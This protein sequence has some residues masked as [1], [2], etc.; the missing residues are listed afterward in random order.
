MKRLRLIILSIKL[1]AVLA[2][3][4][5]AQAPI[6][7]LTFEEAVKIALENSVKLGAEKNNLKLSQ[8]T[9]LGSIVGI[10][11]N[12]SINSQGNRTSGNSF[13]PN[14]GIVTNGI[15]DNITANISA[16][17][18][19][20]SGFSQINRIKQFSKQLEAQ[21]YLI[22]RT[23]Q[24][25]INDVASN[26]LQVMLDYQSYIIAK[27][28]HEALTKQLE[29][30]RELVNLGARSP[31]DEYNQEAQTKGAELRE[32][33]ALIAF[34]NDQA[35][36]S[37]ILLL[38]PLEQFEVEAPNWDINNLL[39]DSLNVEYLVDQSKEYRS[40]YQRALRLAKATYFAMNAIKGQ[41]FP[42]LY[43]FGA[44]GSAYNYQ[45]DVPKYVSV[46]ET[47]YTL[48]E[49]RL[50]KITTTAQVNNPY[51]PQSFGNQFKT[52]NIYKQF[53]LQLSIP[54]FRGLQNRTNYVEQKIMYK[55]SQLDLKN[56]EFQ[57]RNDVVRAVRLFEGA[58]K[59]FVVTV[60]QLK[61]ADFAFQLESERFNLGVTNFVDYAN[62]NRAFVQAKIEKAQAEFRL[63]FQRISLDYA[64]GTLKYDGL[65]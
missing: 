13:N 34:N 36:L 5:K 25:V 43:A 19:L 11:P 7:I 8:V 16:N 44:Y 52:N 48:I 55:N 21:N 4:T 24:D 37:Q 1:L 65:K 9:R 30:V 63:M 50:E 64:I 3:T 18:N 32:V 39:A 38:D 45:H 59:A 31:V 17:L 61:A 40:D 22:N 27:E 56:I 49:N 33:Q 28:N 35:L 10:G 2:I 51:Y 57:I 6:R 12:V 14:T 53:G 29:M 20:F 54:L 42:T 47:D 60:A 23:T 15:R 58:K 41:L 26:Y 62:A 46:S